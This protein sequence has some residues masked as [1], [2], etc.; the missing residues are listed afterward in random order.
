MGLCESLGR[1]IDPG[2]T[3]Y[4]TEDDVHVPAAFGCDLGCAF[5]YPEPPDHGHDCSLHACWRPGCCG[6][7]N[8]KDCI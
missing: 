8:R 5:C 6:D 2:E 4:G 7:P 1:R 3:D